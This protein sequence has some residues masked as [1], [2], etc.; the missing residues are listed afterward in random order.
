MRFCSPHRI[1]DHGHPIGSGAFHD[2]A[3]QAPGGLGH[4]LFLKLS[5]A[6][7][8]VAAIIGPVFP[9]ISQDILPEAF[10]GHTVKRHLF[11]PF[12]LPLPD[13]LP[14]RSRPSPPYR[15]SGRSKTGW[16]PH[17]ARNSTKYTPKA[18][19]PSRPGRLPDN[20]FLY[21]LRHII[22]DHI[23][24]IRLINPHAKGIGSHHDPAPVINKV[25]LVLLPFLVRQ[26]G[27][28]PG[29]MKNPPG[30]GWAHTSST[31]LPGNAVNDPA[32]LAPRSHV[33]HDR[34]HL[35]PRTLHLKPEIFPVKP[36]GQASPDPSSSKRVENILPHLLRG[37]GGKS[38]HDRAL[39]QAWRIKS[40]IRT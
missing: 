27:M 6:V 19:R 18:G 37:C 13:Q 33:G 2:T 14:R 40:E 38:P 11:Q 5:Q 39:A 10:I 24:H 35:V 22:M 16:S 21:V 36:C 29:G 1:N 12:P 32:V 31:S 34:P 17:P 7:G 8:T 28:I 9:K 26:A 4:I 3:Q 20:S 23:A 25:I 15:S 30:S